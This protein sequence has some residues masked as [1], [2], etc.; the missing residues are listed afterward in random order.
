MPDGSR[1]FAASPDDNEMPGG[2]YRN[3]MWLPYPGDNVLL[4]LGMCGSWECGWVD[5]L[6]ATISAARLT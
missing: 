5:T 6:A 4:C 3:Q 1:A 2:M